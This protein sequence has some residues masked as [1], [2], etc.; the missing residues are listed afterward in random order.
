MLQRRPA[1]L[2]LYIT[3]KKRIIFYRL[4]KIDDVDLDSQVLKLLIK[5]NNISASSEIFYDTEA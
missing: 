3:I 2:N 5:D 1:I 4:N